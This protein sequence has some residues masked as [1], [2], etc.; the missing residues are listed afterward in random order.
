MQREVM[1][2][3]LRDLGT[4]DFTLKRILSMGDRAQVRVFLCFLRDMGVFHRI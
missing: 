1:R 2:I 3:H 4:L